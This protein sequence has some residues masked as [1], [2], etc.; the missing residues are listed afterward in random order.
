MTPAE[1]LLQVSDATVQFRQLRRAPVVAV[2]RVSLDVASKETVA[3][4]GESGS[5]KTTLGRAILGL[6]R[7]DAGS[8]V[9][10][11]EEISS[12]SREE[13]RRLSAHVQLVHQDP[14]GSL[15]PSRTIAQ[16]LV[17][18]LLVHR[19]LS[20]HELREELGRA[21]DLVGLPA[22]VLSRYP[23]A[24]SG[25]Q[26]Q[27]I[28][29]ARALIVRPEIV[30]ADEPVSA[31]D[32]S[33]Q[34]QVLNLFADLRETLGVSFLF[35]SHNLAVVEHVSDRI[36]VLYR[37]RVVE[38]GPAEIVSSVPAHPYTRALLAAVPVPDPRRQAIRRRQRQELSLGTT[39]TAA[40]TSGDAC[41]FASRCPHR[42]DE[43]LTAR[44]P[45]ELSAAGTLVAC[46]RHR[47]IGQAP[48][49]VALTT[50]GQRSA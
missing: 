37:G 7:L 26:R 45:L 28:A 15:N 11:G 50:V 10:R 22:S 32:L 13:R 44:P 39:D 18:P 38:S 36:V 6:V 43:C 24:F 12:A 9:F 16:T 5:G 14:Y 20:A 21:L 49:G 29:I 3:L 2:D 42:R 48:D 40:P 23:N 47:E 46:V 4:V 25:G 17:E 8:I 31:L 34:A 33:T 35:I 27:R 19:S 30:I 41:V 1:N